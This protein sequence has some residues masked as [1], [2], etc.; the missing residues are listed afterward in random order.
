M[1]FQPLDC[2]FLYAEIFNFACPCAHRS[3]QAEFGR[4]R[5]E[6]KAQVKRLGWCAVVYMRFGAYVCLLVPLY[7][8]YPFWAVLSLLTKQQP[9]KKDNY[10]HMSGQLRQVKHSVAW[11]LADKTIWCIIILVYP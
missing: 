11:T 10:D 8:N 1:P 5:I 6:K 2:D 9:P 4:L 3:L 7:H